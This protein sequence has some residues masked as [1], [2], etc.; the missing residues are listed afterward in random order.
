MCRSLLRRWLVRVLCLLAVA[1]CAA[2]APPPV[3]VLPPPCPA[4]V[5]SAQ[6]L[7]VAVAVMPG[8]EDAAVSVSLRNP[9]WGNR[10]AP[11]TIVEFSDFQCPFTVRAS[12][13]RWTS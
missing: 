4:P 6:P 12:S 10:A 13:R 2:P 9:V 7:A 5:A 8:E 3:V 11:V 1:A